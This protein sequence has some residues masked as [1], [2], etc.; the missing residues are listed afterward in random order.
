[1]MRTRMHRL[2]FQHRVQHD[3]QCLPAADRIP[4]ETVIL[5]GHHCHPG[6]R[7]D[8]ARKFLHDRFQTLEPTLALGLIVGAV[9]VERLG[10]A[11]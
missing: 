2:G 9:F 7:I 8:I 5:P 6:T 3:I 11:R 4:V 10:A 1:M